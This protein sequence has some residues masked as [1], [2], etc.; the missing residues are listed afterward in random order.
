ME[1]RSTSS[2]RVEKAIQELNLKTEIR[3]LPSS[4]RTARQ[5][6]S[7]VGCQV[8]Q[9]VK[10]LVFKGKSSQNPILILTSG[11]NQVN[12]DLMI[13]MVGEKIEFASAEFVR[14][15]TGFSI[16]GVSPIGLLK[17]LPIY[18]DRDLLELPVI[19]AAAGTPNSVFSITPAE[20]VSATGAKA[21]S[22]Y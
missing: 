17:S 13:D 3:E 20:L 10:S 19:W 2:Q 4:T 7:A 16:G 18:I 8:E 5:A 14:T 21:I 12:E 1:R 6:A 15:E 9:I 11:S 22:V